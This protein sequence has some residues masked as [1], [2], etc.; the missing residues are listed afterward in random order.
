M[1]FT[2]LL[3]LP[4]ILA[5]DTSKELTALIDDVVSTCRVDNFEIL[6]VNSHPSLPSGSM[7]ASVCGVA[8]CQ[9]VIKA[10]YEA[11]ILIPNMTNNLDDVNLTFDDLEQVYS[12][13]LEVGAD[14]LLCLLA[15]TI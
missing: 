3:F 2:L 11:A 9:P 1:R 14:R 15:C 5:L 13:S 10:L 6:V 8:A 7:P 12:K 4:G